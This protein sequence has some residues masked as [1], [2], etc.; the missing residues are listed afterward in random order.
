[1]RIPRADVADFMLNQLASDT[2]RKLPP[3]RRLWESATSLV[4]ISQN[5]SRTITYSTLLPAII[6]SMALR[7]LRPIPREY[8]L[9]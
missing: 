6:Y 2:Y 8:A 9:G 4:A 1:V 3:T 7:M 5:P